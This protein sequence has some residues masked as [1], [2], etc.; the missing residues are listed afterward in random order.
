MAED[1]WLTCHRQFVKELD[2]WDKQG[3]WDVLF[4]GDSIIEEWRGTFL[5]APWG[6]FHDVRKVWDEFFGRKSY[7][8]HS[9][10]IASDGVEQLLWRIQHGELP[11]QGQHHPK[12]VVVHVGTNDIA[13]ECTVE[14]GQKVAD[15]MQTL[16]D[17]F[18]QHLPSTHIVVMAILPKGEVWPNR[19]SEAI[20]EANT[21]IQGLTEGSDH[22]HFLDIGQ[23]FLSETLD[24]D[25]FEIKETLM[26][27][28]MHP[29]AVG[30]RIIATRLEPLVSQLVASAKDMPQR[31]R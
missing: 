23:A 9:M 21:R 19:C 28:S 7:R 24:G 14:T 29:S 8:A 10:G 30:M 20:D 31:S 15:Q 1:T 22:L 26:P 12:V 18:H 13:G 6:P 5:G 16:L 17:E 11:S 3:G 2:E 27:D 25:R 4:Y